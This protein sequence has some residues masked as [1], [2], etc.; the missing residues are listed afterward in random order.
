MSLERRWTCLC[1]CGTGLLALAACA[2]SVES[3]QS[4]SAMSIGNNTRP[5]NVTVSN[6]QRGA[7]KVTWTATLPGGASYSCEADDMVRRPYCFRR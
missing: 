7:T 3:L 1:L 5:A 6:V 4:A 2:S